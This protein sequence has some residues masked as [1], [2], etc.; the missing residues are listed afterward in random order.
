MID[1]RIQHVTSA[2]GHYRPG[3][4]Q[5]QQFVDEMARNG[6]RDVPVYDFSGRV[7]IL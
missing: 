7:R 6:L 3:V 1:G 2:S 4:P 5:M